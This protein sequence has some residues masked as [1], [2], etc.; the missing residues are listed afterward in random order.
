MV[1]THIF[2]K[3]LQFFEKILLNFS[4][5][6]LTIDFSGALVEEHSAF[7]QHSFSAKKNKNKKRLKRKAM[8]QAKSNNGRQTAYIGFSFLVQT[9]SLG[10]SFLY[11]KKTDPKTVLIFATLHGLCA[12]DM[13][14]KSITRE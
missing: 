8:L 7:E 1:D 14:H 3:P 13:L 11:K 10:V 9:S 12:P 2:L 5:K 4:I 6:F